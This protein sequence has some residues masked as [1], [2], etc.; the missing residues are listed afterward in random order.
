MVDNA[1]QLNSALSSSRPTFIE[2]YA[3]WCPHCKRMAP[4]MAQLRADYEGKVNVITIEGEAHEELM[5]EFKVESYPTY[6]IVKDKSVVWTDG[7][8]MPIEELKAAIDK[9]L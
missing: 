3:S 6:F 7:G 1:N 2:F 5:K 4:V 8:E 9:A